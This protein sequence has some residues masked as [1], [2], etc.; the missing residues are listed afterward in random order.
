VTVAVFGDSV[1]EGYTIPHYL[2]DGLVPQ[3]RRAMAPLGFAAGG[4]GLIPATPVRW[5]FNAAAT[6]G[7]IA[8]V[9]GWQLFGYG[10]QPGLD[11]PSGYSAVTTSPLAS[12]TATVTDPHIEVLYTTTPDPGGFTV[13]VPGRAW[14]IDTFRPGPPVDSS[15]QIVLPPGT[16]ELTVHGP[17]SGSLTFEGVVARRDPVPGPAQVEIDNLGHAGKLPDSDLAPRVQQSLVAQRYDVSVFLFGYIGALLASP[18]ERYRYQHSMIL[19]GR[20][21]RAGGGQCVIA[22]PTPMP[23]PA[24]VLGHLATIDRRIARRT[25]CAYTSV[26]SRLWPSPVAAERRGWVLA[27]DIHPTAAGY[28]LVARALA[29]MI[30][31]LARPRGAGRARGQ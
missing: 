4:V 5:H 20:L 10:T 19:R 6:N 30:A 22:A 11:G 13:T 25:G 17:N 1:A 16:Q 26:L 9:D 31:R 24:G 18:F 12:A 21:A 3:L 28:R 15:T 8:P 2:R 27:D 23:V 14:T 29:P 7:A